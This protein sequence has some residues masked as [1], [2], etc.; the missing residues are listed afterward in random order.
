MQLGSQRRGKGW[1][2][3]RASSR[4]LSNCVDRGSPALR[5]LLQLRGAGVGED[6]VVDERSGGGLAAFG[7]P[8]ARDHGREVGTPHAGDEPRL[9]RDRHVAGRGAA[10]QRE[11]AVEVGRLRGPPIERS[12]QQA[13]AA[14]VGVDDRHARPEYPAEGRALRRLP[15]SSPD[16]AARPSGAPAGR[17]AGS[18]LRRD[19]QA[20][21]SEELVVPAAHASFDGASSC[22]R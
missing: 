1:P 9:G 15:R 19:R 14:G 3:A 12:P 13:Q 11:T 2:S 6:H 16:P 18:L 17:Y 10:D 8:Q 20:D 7:E 21:R 4:S 5:L 22:P